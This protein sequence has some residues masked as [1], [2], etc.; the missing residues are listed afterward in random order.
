MS[1]LMTSIKYALRD[2]EEKINCYF[3]TDSTIVLSWLLQSPHTLKT[4]VANRIAKIQAETKFKVWHHVRSKDNPADLASRGID[5]SE[6]VDNNL[7]WKG[8]NWLSLQK[9]EWPGSQSSPF[10][11][12]ETDL[13]HI[14]TERVPLVVA[15]VN[16]ESF[17]IANRFSTFTRICLVTAFIM[18]FIRNCKTKRMESRK[19]QISAM[20]NVNPLTRDEYQSAERFWLVKSQT[21]DFPNE[22]KACNEGTDLKRS[23][24]LYGLSPFLDSHGILRVGGRLA[25]APIPYAVKYPII[26]DGH[27]KIAKL[28]IYR[29]HLEMLHGGAQLTTRTIR[30]KYWIIGGRNA[31]RNIIHSCVRCVTMRGQTCTQ[32]MANLVEERVTPIE[33]FTNISLDYC[34]PFEVKRFSG[35]CRTLVKV[36]VSVFICMATRAIHLELA[37]DLTSGAFIDAFQRYAARRGYCATIISDNAKTFVGAKRQMLEIEEIFRKSSHSSVFSTRGIEWKFIMPRSPSQGG[38]HEVAVKLFKHHLWRVMGSNLL[39][40]HELGSLVTR[41]EGCLNSRPLAIQTDDP[42]DHVVVTPAQLIRGSSLVVAP[43]VEPLLENEPI[44]NHHLRKVQYWHQSIWRQWQSDYINNLQCRGR[45]QNKQPNLQIG[46]IVVMKEENLAPHHWALGKI[47]EVHPGSD[48]C[49]RNVT[50]KCGNG[51]TFKRA[52]QK[53][54]K[55]PVG[56]DVMASSP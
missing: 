12:T 7:W 37:H 27:S 39:S 34:G 42:N 55:L 41:I 17:W 35:R 51:S 18:R 11:M 46:D 2:R 5:A 19:R 38:S 15:L 29:T 26:L 4:F 56:Q 21:F 14:E 45:W 22:I 1:R 3:W 30:E 47:I 31:I 50:I 9:C 43:P 24:K 48:G 54:C 33:P 52:V 40:V 25:R 13:N 23:S 16:I 8:P 49:V 10:E 6:L 53:L 44:T 32:Q 36:W 20:E 28:I